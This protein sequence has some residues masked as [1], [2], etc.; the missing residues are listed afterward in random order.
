MTNRALPVVH[1]R[2]VRCDDVE[3]IVRIY[4]QSW[5]AGFLELMPTRQVTS[6]VVSQWTADLAR[7]HPHRWWVAE[8]N[9]FVV[10][11]AGICPSRDPVDPSVG[12][13]DTIAVDPLW[14][15]SGIGRRLMLNAV[16]HLIRDGYREAVLWTLANYERGQRFYEATGWKADG[17]QRDQGRQIRYHRQ[18]A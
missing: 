13:I 3:D 4:I 14:W 10:G 7:P 15:R 5:N 8:A 9:A 11:F 16:E 6:D 17:R 2:D 1:I 18:L 12:E